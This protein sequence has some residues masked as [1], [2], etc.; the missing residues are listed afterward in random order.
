MKKP[1]IKVSVLY[2]HGAD[3]KFDMDYYCGTHVPMVVQL[4]SPEVKSGAVEK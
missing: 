3:T 4:L 2:P 1:M